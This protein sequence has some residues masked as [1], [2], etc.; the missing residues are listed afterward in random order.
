MSR[1]FKVLPFAL[2]LAVV[3]LAVLAASCSSSSTQYRIVDAMAFSPQ[4]EVDI[5]VN[6]TPPSTPTFSGVG[7]GSTEPGSGY[8]KVSSGA[9]TTEVF[10]TGTTS[11]PYFDGALNLGGGSY[12]VVLTGNGTPDPFGVQ[13]VTDTNPTPTSGDVE[14]RILDASPSTPSADVYVGDPTFGCCPQSAKVGSGLLYPASGG[15][16]NFNSGYVNVGVPTSD[17][18]GVWVTYTGTSNVMASTTYTVTVGQLYTVVLLD[19]Y[20]G[21]FPP[22]FM[23]LTP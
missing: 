22:Q 12:T 16:G 2:A 21:G 23:L 19:Q 1:L 15:S 14:F 6:T 10:E 3:A 11:N 7:L 5:Y 9:D 18:L 13:V 4:E 20:G 17:D 8:Q